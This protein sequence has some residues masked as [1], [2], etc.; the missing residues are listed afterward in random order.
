MSEKQHESIIITT[1]NTGHCAVCVCVCLH[2]VVFYACELCLQLLSVCDML[3]MQKFLEV[4]NHKPC[5]TYQFKGVFF[6]FLSRA[7]YSFA[8][9]Q[10]P[11]VQLSNSGTRLWKW[12]KRA[13]GQKHGPCKYANADATRRDACPSSCGRS[14]L[15]HVA[16]CICH[17][18]IGPQR[19]HEL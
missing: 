3:M 10:T 15:L 16:C 12:H 6:F 11:I 13:Y 7:F 2:V 4:L 19:K 18:K 5:L 9:H 17:L 1:N 14:I 8:M